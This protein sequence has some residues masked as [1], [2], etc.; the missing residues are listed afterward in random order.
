MLGRNVNPADIEAFTSLYPLANHNLIR[1]ME[2]PSLNPQDVNFFI[3]ALKKQ[4]IIDKILFVHLGRVNQEDI[5]PRLADF[6]LQIEGADW[7]VISGLFQKNL[8]ISLRNV[9]YVK[10][11][12]DIVRSI[13]ND[14]SIAG[15][16]RTMAKAVMPIKEFMQTFRINSTKAIQAKI[17]E[18]F[19]KGLKEYTS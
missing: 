2:N 8:V 12:G 4:L 9:G 11:A 3:K 17:I 10:S 18:L 19:V 15:G 7:T 14:S 16:H 13:F 6:C 1:R 5:I